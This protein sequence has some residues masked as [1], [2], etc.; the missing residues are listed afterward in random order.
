MLK[1]WVAEKEQRLLKTTGCIGLGVCRRC[2]LQGSSE[3]A[4]ICPRA[5][6][7]SRTSVLQARGWPWGGR[8]DRSH[9]GQSVGLALSESSQPS[10]HFAPTSP[11]QQAT[12]PSS[13][14]TEDANT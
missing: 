5:R 3:E 6:V 4:S 2:Q 7:G 11:S 10:P 14:P 13:R 1:Y 9:C 12:L 8:G